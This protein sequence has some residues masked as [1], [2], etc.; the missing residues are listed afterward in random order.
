LSDG[1]RETKFFGTADIPNFFRKPYGPG[2]ALAGD[3][4]Y[5]KDPIG[6]QGISDAF[7]D[8]ERLATALDD[9]F[10]GRRPLD[11]AFAAYE[12]ARNEEVGAMYEF[13]CE[14]AALEPPPPEMQQL[15]GAL[16]GN[17]ADTD[18]FFGLLAGTVPVPE[19]FS[20]ENMQRINSSVS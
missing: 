4:G 15:F 19:F 20:P 17:Q 7:R 18:R 12:R 1:Q 3:A 6:A 11:E 8:A 10:S 16:R 5:H 9:G 2:W 14:L 13:N